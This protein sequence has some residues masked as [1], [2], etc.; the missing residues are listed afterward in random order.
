METRTYFLP[1]PI[2]TNARMASVNGRQILTSAARKWYAHAAEELGLQRPKSI[3]G[4]VEIRIDLNP[5][6]KRRFDIDNRAKVALDA[7]VKNLIIEDDDCTIVHKLT[8][9][10]SDE[11]ERPGAYV[12]V[13]PRSTTSEGG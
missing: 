10:V 6:T 4:P 7:L 12:T 2:S 9:Q 3:K 8:L 11:Y 5:P 1:W 13:S